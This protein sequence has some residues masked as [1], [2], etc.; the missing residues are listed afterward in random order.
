VR[1]REWS[2]SAEGILVLSGPPGCGKT[3]AATWWAL[4]G[5]HAPRFV[6]ATAFATA[7]RYQNDERDSWLAG[8]SLVLDDLGTEYADSKG[9]FLVDLD[10]LVDTFYADKK[11]LVI[12]TNCTA[13]E[14]KKR[15]GERVTDR[16][17][18]C[19][20]WFSISDVSRRRK[21]P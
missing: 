2:P 16:I 1:V 8:R 7:S 6:R 17:R 18:E 11:P 19:G 4:N 15:Y 12:T 14:F 5:K 3:V 20:S 13:A 10:E 9:S 21:A